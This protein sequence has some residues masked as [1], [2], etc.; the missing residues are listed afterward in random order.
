MV[1]LLY[2]DLVNES[3]IVMATGI[4]EFDTRIHELAKWENECDG[5]FE[6]I[7]NGNGE[8]SM[9]YIVLRNSCIELRREIIKN[10][11]K[12]GLTRERIKT[13]IKEARNKTATS[14]KRT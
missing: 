8:K 10:A 6:E 14:A 1:E 13:E 3:V 7:K 2:T 12:A 4:D 5:L 11:M 9:R